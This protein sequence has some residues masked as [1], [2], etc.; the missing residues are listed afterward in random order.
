MAASN[1]QIKIA[2]DG[3]S[4]RPNKGIRTTFEFVPDAPVSRFVLWMA[5][6]KKGLLHNS[7]NICKGS[8]RAIVR[9]TGQ[10]GK[11]NESR[12]PLN[13]GRCRQNKRKAKRSSHRRARVARA[14]AAG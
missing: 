2:L 4:T 9:F 11:R 12:P 3:K 10:N 6:G 7:T 1:G 14:S 8:H 13:N 5:G